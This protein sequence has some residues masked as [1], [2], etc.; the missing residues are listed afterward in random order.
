M[1]SQIYRCKNQKRERPLGLKKVFP[2]KLDV[3]GSKQLH[4][5]IVNRSHLTL[6]WAFVLYVSA[7][8]V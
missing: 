6:Q 2:L 3:E 8:A 4:F 5:L 1:L 7:I